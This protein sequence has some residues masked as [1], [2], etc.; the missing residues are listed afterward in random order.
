MK[1]IAILV[2]M[3]MLLFSSI[4]SKSEECIPL[5]NVIIESRENGGIVFPLTRDNIR[6][7]VDTDSLPSEVLNYEGEFYLEHRNLPV[8]RIFN[9]KNNCADYEWFMPVY[10]VQL[11]RLKSI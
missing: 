11:L 4:A 6:V 5:V 8:V 2:V 7:L 10:R 9:M 3:F 1:T